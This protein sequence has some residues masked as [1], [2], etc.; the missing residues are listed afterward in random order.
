VGVVAGVAVEE[1]ATLKVMT[2][3][4]MTLALC[5]TLMKGRKGRRERRERRERRRV[6]A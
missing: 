4:T 1:K 6:W 3:A 5:Q 2:A